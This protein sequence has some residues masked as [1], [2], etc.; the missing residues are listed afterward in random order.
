[1]S[2]GMALQSSNVVWAENNGYEQVWQSL[3][4]ADRASQPQQCHTLTNRVKTRQHY[5]KSKIMSTAKIAT[6]AT[7][8]FSYYLYK[9]SSYSW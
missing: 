7:Q 3:K 5:S 1:M 8:L 4:C 6:V 9:H 2:Q